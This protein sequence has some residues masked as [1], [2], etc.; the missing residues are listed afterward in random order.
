MEKGLETEDR[1]KRAEKPC[2]PSFSQL[3]VAAE[4]KLQGIGQEQLRLP[5]MTA[6]GSRLA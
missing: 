3:P 6:E 4:D 5:Q 1:C 2:G